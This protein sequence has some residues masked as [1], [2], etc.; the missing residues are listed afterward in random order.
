MNKGLAIPKCLFSATKFF[1]DSFLAFTLAEVLITLGVIGIVAAMTLPALISDITSIKFKTGFKKSMSVLNQAVN[2]NKTKFDFDFASP[3]SACIDE[4]KDKADNVTSLCGIFNTNLSTVKAYTHSNL[5]TKNK[6]LYYLEVYN[7]GATPD[8]LLKN[9]GVRMY[10]YQMNDGALFAFRDSS[11][12]QCTLKNRTLEEALNDEDFQ[13]FCVGF[14]DV[15]GIANPNR[16]VRCSDGKSHTTDINADCTVPN[17]PH[18]M[19]DVFPV[20]FYDSVVAPASAAAR[21]VLYGK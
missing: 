9:F 10:L 5:Y 15:N 12:R 21:Y 2:L 3:G 18:Y 11:S 13:K 16:E 19:G 8:T 17:G 6:K 14:I 20:A 1:A 4:T 7:N